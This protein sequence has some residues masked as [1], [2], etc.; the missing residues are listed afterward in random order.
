[1]GLLAM[2]AAACPGRIVVLTVDHGLRAG[3][4]AEAAHVAA[5]CDTHALPHHLLRWAGPYPKANV[6]AEARRARYQLLGDW[7]TANQMPYLLTAHH[8]EDQAE[9]LLMRLARGSGLAGLTGIRRHRLL[10]SGVI[11]LRPCLGLPRARLA[12][13]AAAAGFVPVVDPSNISPRHDRTHTRALL[14]REPRLLPAG[15]LAQAANALAEAEASLV[16]ATDRAFASRVTATK[17]GFTLD[18]D[19]LPNEL[20]RRLLDQALIRLG[21]APRGSAVARLLARGGGTLG[22]IRV[23]AGALWHLTKAAPRAP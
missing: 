13:E 20:Q 7:C 18:L 21:A 17:A 4:A 9:T 3:S 15:Q 1:M 2:A 19:G 5:T 22:S 12:A 11:V 23:R 8:A 6:Q 14:A 16:W 10:T